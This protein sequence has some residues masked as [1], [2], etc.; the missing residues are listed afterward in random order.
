M[1]KIGSN[2]DWGFSCVIHAV[3]EALVKVEH[4]LHD[5]SLAGIYSE[6]K[7]RAQDVAVS[8]G[9]HQRQALFRVS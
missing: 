3:G 8:S 2:C 7:G 9:S 5:I 1:S 6:G 4:R